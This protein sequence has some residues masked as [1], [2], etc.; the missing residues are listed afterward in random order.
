MYKNIQKKN[1]RKPMLVPKPAN[2]TRWNARHDETQRANIIMGD[3]CLALKELLSPHGDDFDLLTSEEMRAGDIDRLSYT[4][5]DK[6]VLRQFEATA[7]D[8]KAFS[9]FTQKKGNTNAYLLLEVQLVL[10]NSR[11]DSFTMPSGE[12]NC[13]YNSCITYIY[14]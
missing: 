5:D 4:D 7:K 14:K 3:I 9:M 2:D 8:A 13:I 10:A 11:R 1:D 12:S 6:M